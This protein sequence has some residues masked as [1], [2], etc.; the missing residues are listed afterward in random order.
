MA[1]ADVVSEL[2][3]AFEARDWTALRRLYHPD[4]LIFTVTG[5]PVPLA[6]D[7]IVGELERASSEVMYSVHA[8]RLVV[9]DEHAA[10]ITGRMRRQMPRGGF[11]DASHV[12]LL[13]VLD[14]LVYRQAVHHDPAAA[15]AAYELL[16]IDLGVSGRE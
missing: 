15:A 2:S 16:G 5:G 6:A 4:A 3:R 1:A 11:E 7:E 14:E 10:I 13:T 12:W 8:D 9:L